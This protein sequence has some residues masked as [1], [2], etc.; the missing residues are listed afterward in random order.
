MRIKLKV[1]KI[2]VEISDS[3]VKC[4]NKIMKELITS[5]Y[6]TPSNYGVEDGFLPVLSEFLG[7]KM[8]IISIEDNK[9]TIY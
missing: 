2:S 7:K 5:L 1:N 9:N 6:E 8:E 4:D 3:G